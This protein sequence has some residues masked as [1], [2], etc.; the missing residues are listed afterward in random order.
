MTPAVAQPLSVHAPAT[1]A[2]TLITCHANADFDAFAAMLAARHLYAPHVLLFPGTQERGLQKLV[3]GLDTA[4]FAIMEPAAIPWETIGRLVVVDTR[5][6]G[7]VPHVARLLDR[8]EVAVEL[9]DHHPD[10][11]DDITTPNSHWAR[12]G[13]VTSLIVNELAARGAALPAEDATLLGL[14]IYGDT[15]SFTYSSTTQ[16]DFQAAAWLLGQGMPEHLN[17]TYAEL[18]PYFTNGAA[19]GEQGR[20]ASTPGQESCGP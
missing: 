5:Q 8:P 13:A 2:T 17:R 15:G 11:P 10:S 16:A 20:N 19:A 12:V 7:R 6:R 14:G 3:A 18:K 9:W 4:T 1:G